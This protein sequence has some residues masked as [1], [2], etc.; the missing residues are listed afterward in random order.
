MLLR[1]DGQHREVS[2][3]TSSLFGRRVLPSGRGPR[4]R[5]GHPFSSDVILLLFTYLFIWDCIQSYSLGCWRAG[6]VGFGIG[7]GLGEETSLNPSCAR[8]FL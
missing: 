6:M 2:L 8:H 1:E 7:M 5:C 4:Y 3:R